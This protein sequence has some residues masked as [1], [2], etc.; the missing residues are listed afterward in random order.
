[1]TAQHGAITVGRVPTPGPN[2]AADWK[3]ELA[4]EHVLQLRHQRWRTNT[5]HILKLARTLAITWLLLRHGA[6]LT[7]IINTF[8]DGP[9]SL[10]R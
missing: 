8:T 3:H 10:G 2:N 5:T 4:R 1:V 9:P 6:D 7:D